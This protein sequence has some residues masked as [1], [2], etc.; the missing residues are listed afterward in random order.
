M[1]RHATRKRGGNANKPLEPSSASPPAKHRKTMKYKKMQCSPHPEKNDFSCFTDDQLYKLRDRWNLRHP[2]VP[3][4][5]ESPKDIWSLL[6]NNLSNTC[7]KET[8]WLRQNFMTPE[9]SKEMLSSFAPESPATWKRD[10][11]AWLSSLDI[12]SV[13]KQYEKS[14][15][16]FEFIGPSPIDYDTIELD[17]VCVFEEICKFNLQQQIAHGKTKVGFIFNTDTHDKPGKHWVSLFVNIK[18]G[19]LYFFDSAGDKIPRN[20]N[21]L[22]KNIIRQGKSLPT[23]IQF[24]FDQ[25]Y[26]VEHQYGN[27]ECG[28][29]SLYFIVHMLQDKLTAHYL[30]THIITDKYVNKFRKIY[31]NE[32]L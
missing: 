32:E 31:F 20:I 15:K 27:T 5:S 13:M 2:D 23:P 22:V 6:K 1:V 26:P 11:N 3:I 8:C 28:I 25:N 12:L 16:C 19:F 29:Y 10:P 14:Y 21:K 18:K 24:Q 9:M 17:G 30:K 4:T 7:N